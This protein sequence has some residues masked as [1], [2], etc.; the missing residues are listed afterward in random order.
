MLILWDRNVEAVC[1]YGFHFPFR[2]QDET[3]ARGFVFVFHCLSQMFMYSH[4]L[5]EQVPQQML[6]EGRA[7]S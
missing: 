3:T 5:N 1:I 7:V 4:N 2:K 6:S